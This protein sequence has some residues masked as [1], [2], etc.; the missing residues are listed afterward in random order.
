MSGRASA[1]RRREKLAAFAA[2]GA[3]LAIHLAIHA[4]RRASS[5]SSRRSTAP[6]ARS[7]SL[8]RASWPDEQI[9]RG[10]L[11][12]HRGKVAAA[13]D[14]AHRADPRR[15][16]ARRGRFPR[17][18]ALR[19]RL[20]PALSRR[21]ARE[22]TSS[23]HPARGRPDGRRD[24]TPEIST[25]MSRPATHRLR[26]A[27]RGAAQLRS[28]RAMP[29]A[30]ASAKASAAVLAARFARTAWR[31]HAPPARK[32]GKQREIDRAA[33]RMQIES[34]LAP[35]LVILATPPAMVTRGTGWARRYLSMPPTKSPMSISA[36]SGRP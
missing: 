13:T 7:R 3:T 5:P 6:T 31:S 18:R 14:R 24:R 33:L 2:T 19:S 12:D 28:P 34:A 16:R 15:P 22:E 21:R 20:S 1:C 29:S 23:A 27:L 10:T 25:A 35:S 26:R 17:Q 4:H 8:L 30:R 9:L 11:A 32:L 36:I